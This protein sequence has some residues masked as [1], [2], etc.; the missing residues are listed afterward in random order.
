MPKPP[1]AQATAGLHLGQGWV[2]GIGGPIP[3][4]AELLLNRI[5]KPLP[6]QAHGEVGKGLCQNGQ[7]E[8]SVRT[9]KNKIL[10][11]SSFS[12]SQTRFKSKLPHLLALQLRVNSASFSGPSFPAL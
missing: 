5:E 3:Q 6:R 8:N 12:A 10:K 7:N 2:Q 9:F 4:E 1:Q 11:K